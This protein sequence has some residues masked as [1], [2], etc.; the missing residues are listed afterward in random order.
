MKLVEFLAFT[1]TMALGLGLLM[2]LRGDRIQ[3]VVTE[4]S[5]VVDLRAAT[6]INFIYAGILFYFKMHSKMPMSTT[7]VFISLLS[8]REL[9]MALRKT[10]DFSLSGA[11][12]IVI[13]DLVYVT[14]GLL[15]SVI[16]A[17][18]SNEVFADAVKGV[19]K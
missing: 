13:R 18:A 1:G 15:V 8:G 3:E 19:F 5:Q 7:W 16:I 10:S 17:F 11:L 4:K 14:F 12:K 2:R 9:A 6:L